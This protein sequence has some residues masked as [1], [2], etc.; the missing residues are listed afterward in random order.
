MVR[1]RFL[2]KTSTSHSLL[3]SCSS[4]QPPLPQTP[5]LRW[6]PAPPCTG[7]WT[8]TWPTCRAGATPPP[9]PCCGPTWW[10]G[11]RSWPRWGW[12]RSWACWWAGAGT[13]LGRDGQGQGRAWAGTGRGRDGHRRHGVVMLMWVRGLSAAVS[14]RAYAGVRAR[15]YARGTCWEGR[16]GR[17]GWHAVSL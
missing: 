4:T 13:G 3:T 14:P 8:S 11:R 17:W 5:P 9:P 16:L 2:S 7:C 6:P 10:R 15:V 1:Y 12:S